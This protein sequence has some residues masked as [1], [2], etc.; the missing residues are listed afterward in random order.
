MRAAGVAECGN[1]ARLE[2]DPNNTADNNTDQISAINGVALHRPRHS[3]TTIITC[4][5][6]CWMHIVDTAKMSDATCKHL[7][8]LVPGQ[9]PAIPA[10][11]EH[12]LGLK[13]DSEQWR[14]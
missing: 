6:E 11:C 3:A 10:S 14:W 2:M 4:S 8:H 9:R 13:S 12:M 5:L 1:I 7:S